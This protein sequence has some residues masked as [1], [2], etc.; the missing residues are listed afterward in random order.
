MS[1]ERKTQTVGYIG[2]SRNPNVLRV[3]LQGNTGWVI[4]RQLER[5]IVALI[6]GEETPR[7][8]TIYEYFHGEEEQ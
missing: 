1:V 2:R 3:K 4:R 8:V 7:Y 5:L 6:H